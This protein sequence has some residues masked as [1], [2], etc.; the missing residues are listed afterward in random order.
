MSRLES[1]RMQLKREWCDVND[2]VGVVVKQFEGQ[3]GGRMLITNPAPNL[4]LVQLDEGLIE[5]S[6][7]NLLDNAINHTPPEVTIVLSTGVTGEQIEIS[8]RDNGPGI[9]AADLDRVFE[10]FYRGA[11]ARTGGT[12]L[13]L[14]IARGLAEAHGGTL[15]AANMPKGG[16][17]FTL[18]LPLGKAPP[19]VAEAAP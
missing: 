18:R 3:L 7:A 14:A 16:A 17:R 11:G 4:P 12:G 1:G 13:G 15:T 10:K 8:V 9:S 19:P 6:L 5:Q 2:L